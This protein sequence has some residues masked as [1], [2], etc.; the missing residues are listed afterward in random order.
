[1]AFLVEQGIKVLCLDIDGTLYPK[2]MLNAVMLR[3]TFPSPF[4]A[5]AFN[6]SRRAYRKEQEHEDTLPATREGLLER[7]TSLVLRYL[8]KKDTPDGRKTYR[9]KIEKQFYKAWERS[10]RSIHA[11]GDLEP[12]LREAKAAGLMI[13]V[14]SDFPISDKLKTL[15][16]EDLVD[17]KLSSEDSGYLKPSPK[18]FAFLLSKIGHRPEEI[19]YVGDSYEKD[20]QGSHRAGMYSALIKKSARGAYPDADLV[21]G[22]WKEFASLVL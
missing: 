11:F 10:F 13:A 6:R 14:F 18:A 16:I 22:S 9:R 21:F 8:G 12:V 5:N 7:Q 2:W 19:L 15:G 4:L 20:C 3:S 17:L 1:M